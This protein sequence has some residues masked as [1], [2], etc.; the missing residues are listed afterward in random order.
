MVK[1]SVVIP[2]Y[3]EAQ[4]I[5]QVIAKIRGVSLDGMDKEIIIV[6]DC[7][8]DGTREEVS[9]Y[10]SS[11]DV[12]VLYHQ[13]NLG[14]G[15]A[16]RSGF[17]A[18][19]GD[20]VVIQDA[21]LEYDPQ[22]YPRLLKPLAEGR[23]DVVYGSRFSG[24]GPHRI[25]FFWHYLANRL[26]TGLSNIMTNLNLTDMETGYKAFRSEILREIQLKEDRF[27]FD[28]EFTARVS[29]L[30]SRIFEV[31]ISYFGRTYAEGKKIS[32]RDGFTVA[33]CIIKYNLSSGG[34]ARRL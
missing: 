33:W 16:L 30:K 26:L 12:R 1:L 14:K 9:K 8:T 5:S 7:S 23:A 31:G 29:R 34:R 25:L 24:P 3:N 11:R 4:T 28:P 18:V 6:D 2:A 27:G 17:K 22:D 13:R 20:F 15:A 32:W 21:D 19:T 10:Q